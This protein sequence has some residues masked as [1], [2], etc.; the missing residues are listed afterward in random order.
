MANAK[1]KGTLISKILEIKN[2]PSE[3]VDII[4]I[5]NPDIF[6]DIKA[7]PEE[8]YE[9]YQ[10]LAPTRKEQEQHLKE[11]NTR[12][13]DHCLIP[14]NF[15]YCNECDFIYNLLTCMIYTIPE[16]E[17]PINNCTLE[18]ESTFN[19]DSNSDNNNDENNDFSSAQYG[20]KNNNNSDFD[21]NPETYITLLDLTKE[22]KLK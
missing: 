3:L 5:P 2:N 21:S 7:G 9:H 16:E 19:P 6:L 17:K 1:I 22:Q 13:Y 4:L 20:N 18:L 12:L 8:F 10:N 15:Q 14:C 11:I